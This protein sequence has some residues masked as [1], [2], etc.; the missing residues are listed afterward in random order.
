MGCIKPT[1]FEWQKFLTSGKNIF[2]ILFKMSK[3]VFR[4]ILFFTIVSL[5]LFSFLTKTKAG[6]ISSITVTPADSSVGAT[7]AYTIQFTPAT[8]V[9][10]TGV[11]LL[12]FIFPQGV[13]FGLVGTSK[14]ATSSPEIGT[15]DNS[16]GGQSQLLSFTT[17]GL[18]AGTA[19]TIKINGVINPGNPGMGIVAIA[20]SN[21]GSYLDGNLQTDPPSTL[22]PSFA[23]GTAAFAGRVTK[24]SDGSAVYNGWVNIFPATPGPSAPPQGSATNYNG[25]YLIST[26]NV[27]SGSN[28]IL[29]AFPPFQGGG[30]LLSDADTLTYSGS[31]V[32]KNFVLA[33]PTKTI[34]GKVSY[35]DTGGGVNGATMNAFKM[36]GSGFTQTTTDSSGNYT[37]LVGGGNWG[38]MPQQSSGVDWSY[39]DK[40]GEVK[41]ADDT[42]SE[43]KTIN[44][45]VDRASA[46]IAGRLVKPGGTPVNPQTDGIGG[47]GVWSQEGKGGGGPLN[48]DGT[49]SI[50]VPV[51]TYNLYIWVPP[52]SLYGAP[53]IAP[54]TVKDNET[55]N[56]GDI[57]LTTKDATITGSVKVEGTNTPV[58]NVRVNAFVRDGGGFSEATTDGSGNFSLLVTAGRWMVMPFFESNAA[59]ALN[60]QPQEVSVTSGGTAGPINFTVKNASSTISGT[61]VDNN[62]SPVPVYGYAFAE[63]PGGGMFGPG[64]LGGPIERGTFSFKVPAD[65]YTVNVGLAPGSGYTPGDGTSVTIADGETKN[66]TVSLKNNDAT[67]TGSILDDSGNPLNNLGDQMFVFAISAG[68]EGHTFQQGTISGNTYTISVAAG[69]WALGYFI[70]PS[71]GYMSAPPDPSMRMSVSSGGTVTKNITLKAANATISGTV[72]QPDGTT[73]ATGVFVSVDNRETEGKEFFNGSPTDSN[74]NYSIRITSG[75]YKVRANVAPGSGYLS[76]AEQNVTVAANSTQTVN[77]TLRQSDGT[78]SGSVTLSGSGVPAFVSAWA[79]DG[80]FAQSV[81]NS[82]GVYSLSV[83]KGTIWHVGAHYETGTTPYESDEVMV[84]MTGSTATANLTLTQANYTLPQ[85][86]S[87]T[88]DASKPKLISLTDGTEI[89]IPAGALATSGNVTLTINPKASLPTKKGDK[90]IWYGY[91]FTATD[92]NGQ[93]ITNFNSSITITFPYTDAQLTRLG[94]TADGLVPSYWDETSGTWKKVSNVTIDTTNKKVTI[95]IDHFTDFAL[96]ANAT[97]STT[98][99]TSSTSTSATTTT[100]AGTAAGFPEIYAN[101]AAVIKKHSLVTIVEEGT[102]PWDAYLSV[103]VYQKKH[104]YHVGMMWQISDI[105]ELW[106]KS[107]FN[108]AK[109]LYPNKP[110]I[111]AIGYEKS[112]L[113][114]LP[115]TSLKL[116]YS[117]DEGK[118]W[119]ILPTSV[120]D[121]NNKMVAALTKSGGY[122]MLVAGYGGYYVTSYVSKPAE[123]VSDKKVEEKIIKEEKKAAPPT[124]I[125]E[126]SPTPPAKKSFFQKVIDFI[127]GR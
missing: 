19:Y 103:T 45:T 67:I 51:G 48:N 29:E 27:N 17:T 114:K 58:P 105:Y 96:T 123:V 16:Q 10:N 49:F 34:S 74:G 75:T 90:P 36:N 63:T 30:N 53:S 18:T 13:T 87:T 68:A 85:A 22:S 8:D 15:L 80:G 107:F 71:S 1:R 117:S 33:T 7:S 21:A 84:N 62:G 118:T 56:L 39:G 112:Q 65:T 50:G 59:Y 109:I 11:V 104:P 86:L 55:R 64:G 3:K 101:Q 28:Y 5:F 20:T 69:D 42:S 88:F 12:R 26:T 116:A 23:I 73:P 77:F 57:T 102:F 24:Q 83:S 60:Q 2:M 124:A 122:Y 94:I 91:E 121:K 125:P 115:E 79:E 9:P 72:Y 25:D 127:L 82:S 119:K 89:N 6:T 81:V 99:T 35:R 43:S 92:S 54:I 14:D 78:I 32:T 93:T 47:L 98:T 97:R 108:D 52:S 76:P 61:V 40:P 41:F 4:L 31:P 111:F 66:I 106:F 113:G 70:D 46:T 37:L 44:F 38:V 120:L 95:T 110:S 126:Q 100:S